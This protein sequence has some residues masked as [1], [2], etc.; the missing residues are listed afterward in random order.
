MRKRK[1][2]EKKM[3]NGCRPMCVCVCFLKQDCV[4]ATISR[5]KGRETGERRGFIKQQQQEVSKTDS[6]IDKSRMLKVFTFKGE[7]N[8]EGGKHTDREKTNGVDY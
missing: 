7:V 6:Y 2:R 5:V 1:M 4:L 8:A 3:L